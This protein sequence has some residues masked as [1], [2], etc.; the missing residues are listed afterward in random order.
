MTGIL[1]GVD[2]RTQHAGQNRLEL[3]VFTLND[4]QR[5][6]MNVFKIQ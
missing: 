3:L 5:F 6:G 2:Q 1:T 4:E